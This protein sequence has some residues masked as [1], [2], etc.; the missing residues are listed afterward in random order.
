MGWVRAKTGKHLLLLSHRRR[1]EQQHTHQEAYAK[2]PTTPYF[3]PRVELLRILFANI[4]L[5]KAE[6][7]S[8]N[9]LDAFLLVSETN[10]PRKYSTGSCAHGA[11]GIVI[12]ANRSSQNHCKFNLAIIMP[13]KAAARQIREPMKYHDLQ[14]A[15]MGARYLFS[16]CSSIPSLV[17]IVL[18][19][20][21]RCRRDQVGEEENAETGVPQWSA[22][23]GT[24]GYQVR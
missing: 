10:P 1:V 9:Q 22:A 18:R 11:N 7:A 19:D 6:L 4:Q 13:T 5:T 3:A 21:Q 8:N 17:M 14:C 20:V 15:T 12:N 16:P 24:G 2:P 23:H